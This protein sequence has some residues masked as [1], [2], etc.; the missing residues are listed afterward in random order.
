MTGGGK[1]KTMQAKGKASWLF[2]AAAA[3]LTAAAMAAAALLCPPV[4]YLNDDVTMRQILS[5]AYT[6]SPD[7]HAVYMRY[8]LTG[9][10]SLLYRIWGQVPWLSVFFGGCFFAVILLAAGELRRLAGGRGWRLWKV[11]LPGGL[12]AAGL[13][14]P[15]FVYLHYTVAAAVLAGGGIFLLSGGRWGKAAG[16]LIL[17]YLV[18]SQVFFLS[19]PFAAFVTLWQLAA[20][21]AGGQVKRVLRPQLICWALTLGGVSVCLLIHSLCYRQEDW[22]EYLAYNAERTELYDYTDFLSAKRYGKDPGRL[23]LDENRLRILQL[24]DTLLLGKDEVSLGETARAVRADQ[25][26]GREALAYLGQCVRK[27]YNSIRYDTA[28][29]SWVWLGALLALAG[30]LAAGRRWGRLALLGALEAGRSAVWVYLIW[31]DRFPERVALALYLLEIPVLLGLFLQTLGEGAGKREEGGPGGKTPSRPGKAAIPGR[32][33]G[34]L[35]LLALAGLLAA[36]AL[37][38]RD[39]SGRVKEQVRLQ[40]EWDALKAYCGRQPDAMY[41]LDVFSVVSYGGMQ[42]E[43]DAENMM[44]LGGWMTGSPLARRRLEQFGGEDA[45]LALLASEDVYLV[46]REDGGTDWLEAYLSERFGEAALTQVDRIVCPGE[47]EG[48]RVFAVYTVNR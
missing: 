26:Q 11:L 6:G 16:L 38:W 44:L 5:G 12:F 20:G 10:L 1:E 22:R 18:R 47:N 21:R 28:P 17:S 2:S 41:L 32:S 29:C 14:L 19:V 39:V 25:E 36:G 3:A 48:G 35:I 15:H 42:Y 34:C 27:Y 45:A 8:P 4:Y 30:R 23:G 24:Y 31:R 46:A 13:L 43:R 33:A 9:L 7:G 40:R 37:Q